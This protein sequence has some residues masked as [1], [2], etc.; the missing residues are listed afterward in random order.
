M[1]QVLVPIDHDEARVLAQVRAV[2]NLP[3]ATSSVEAL[4]LH[5]M[6]DR[7]YG[8]PGERSDSVRSGTWDFPLDYGGE[9]ERTS[10]AQ[11]PT[12]RTAVEYLR[13]RGVEVHGECVPGDPAEDILR[14]ARSVGVDLIVLGGRK[15]SQV[16][17][18]LFGSVSQ[19]VVRHTDRPVMVTGS[20]DASSE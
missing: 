1:Y 8:K 17:S 5:V 6:T 16:G 11:I 12:G 18:I 15:Q 4:L 14:T 9:A 7:P 2:A 13:E 3:A 20:V 19:R 10:I